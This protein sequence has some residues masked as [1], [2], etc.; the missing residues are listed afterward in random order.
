[1]LTITNTARDITK[2]SNRSFAV[3]SSEATARDMGEAKQKIIQVC[4]YL[5]LDPAEFLVT[6]EA[7]KGKRFAHKDPSVFTG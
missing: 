2:L 7:G 1:M 5:R 6:D 3:A 4:R